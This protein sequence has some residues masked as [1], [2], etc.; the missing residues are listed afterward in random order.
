MSV[1]KVT[2]LGGAAD[3]AAIAA[4]ETYRA[5]VIGTGFMGRTHTHAVRVT[6]GEVVGVAGSSAEKAASF[7]AAH[8][9]GR[10]HAD[11]LELIRRDDVDVVH[12][13]TP[14]HLHA[15]LSIA[16]LEA[17]KHVVDRKSVV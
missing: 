15:P 13:C 17:G 7:G 1:R 8:G 9:I 2:S 5:A 16:A 6:G 3:S 10:T 14:N 12:V 11:P 4:P